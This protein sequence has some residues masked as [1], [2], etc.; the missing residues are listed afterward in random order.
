MRPATGIS[1]YREMQ[2]VTATPAELVVLLYEA[3]IAALRDARRAL[4]QKNAAAAHG[5]IVKAQKIVGELLGILDLEQ[6]G[7]VARNLRDLYL[8]LLDHLLQTN[9]RKDGEMLAQAI[10]LLEPLR[11]A[12]SHLAGKAGGKRN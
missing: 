1:R 12:W 4:E 5:A 10:Q 6:G 8:F 9:L 11:D 7:E 2:A 3:A